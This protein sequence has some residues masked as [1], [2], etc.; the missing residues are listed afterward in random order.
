[1]HQ[2]ADEGDSEVSF[3]ASNILATVI[4]VKTLSEILFTALCMPRLRILKFDE[5]KAPKAP[6]NLDNVL[7]WAAGLAPTIGCIKLL[8]M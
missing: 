5:V 8:V 2:D 3:N 1:M 7:A 4:P 6:E